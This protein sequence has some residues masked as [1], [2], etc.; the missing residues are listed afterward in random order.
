MIRIAYLLII[1]GLL[2]L[3]LGFFGGK[4]R[5]DKTVNERLN[6]ALAGGLAIA[7]LFGAYFSYTSSYHTECEQGIR[8]REG[9]ECVGDYVIK[10]GP[11]KEGAIIQ[12]MLAGLAFLYAI[13]SREED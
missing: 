10:K 11:D 9:Y 12:V 13:K 8:T 3:A 1:P 6:A 2:W 7:F 4:W 5:I